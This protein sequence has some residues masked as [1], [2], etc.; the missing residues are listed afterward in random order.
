MGISIRTAIISM[1]SAIVLGLL[2]GVPSY[3]QQEKVAQQ[4]RALFELGCERRDVMTW[5]QHN[6]LISSP[7]RSWVCDREQIDDQLAG[8]LANE[9]IAGG[10]KEWRQFRGQNEERR[11]L[12]SRP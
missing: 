5:H 12:D 2:L 7:K 9:K 10:T 4:Q 6:G 3:F 11:R 8:V 1:A